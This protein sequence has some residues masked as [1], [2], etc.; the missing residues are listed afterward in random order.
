VAPILGS[1]RTASKF[2]RAPR[3]RRFWSSTAGQITLVVFALAATSA[4]LVA[5]RLGVPPN[6]AGIISFC[7]AWVALY[8]IARLHPRRAWWVHWVR[9]AIILIVL[10]LLTI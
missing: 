1:S 5:V 10:L 4:S 2:G 7:V 9:G 8:P 6:T 3:F